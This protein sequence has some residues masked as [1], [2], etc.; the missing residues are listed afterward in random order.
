MGGGGGGSEAMEGEGAVRP[1]QLPCL[2]A[3]SPVYCLMCSTFQEL[4]W[5][6][7]AISLNWASWDWCLVELFMFMGTRYV[8]MQS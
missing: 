3:P 5:A 4:I 1:C 8:D 2:M 7:S 6:T